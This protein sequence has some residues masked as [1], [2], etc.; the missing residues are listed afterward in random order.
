MTTGM[1]FRMGML[2]GHCHDHLHEGTSPT[3]RLQ[4]IV[5]LYRSSLLVQRSNGVGS[6]CRRFRTA[7]DSDACATR[8]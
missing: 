5:R 8:S 7:Q 2:V 4:W 3:H 6:L 1:N